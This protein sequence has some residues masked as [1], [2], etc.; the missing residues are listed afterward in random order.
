MKTIGI[1]SVLCLGTMQLWGACTAAAQ[2]NPLQVRLGS[3]LLGSTVKNPQGQALGSIKDLVISPEDNR[4]LYAVLSFGGV[5]GL[6]E[7]A[8]ALP[9]S[10]LKPAVEAKTFVVEMDPDRLRTAPE[11]NHDNWPQMTDP[12][13]MTSVYTF[14][15]VKPSWQP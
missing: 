5:L 4:V 12:Q 3:H 15:G 13:W 8:V 2:V 10:V 1:L 6:G 14:Y 7:K 9:L 11:F